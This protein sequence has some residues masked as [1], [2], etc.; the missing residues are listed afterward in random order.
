M[1]KNT[2]SSILF[3]IHCPQNVGYAIE[4][5]IEVFKVTASISGF[6]ES[7]IFFSYTEVI[8]A[9]DPQVIECSFNNPTGFEALQTLMRDKNISH[10]VAFDLNYPEKIIPIIRKNNE[11]KLIAYWGAGISSINSGFKLLLK[12]LEWYFRR[13]KPDRFVFESESMRKTA[14]HGRGIPKRNTSVVNLGT[15]TELFIPSE[16]KNYAY[17]L[18]DI[19]LNRSIVFYSGHMEERKG[20]HIIMQ[21]AITLL[22]MQNFEDVHFVICGNKNGEE[23]VFLKMLEGKKAKQNVTFA[24]YRDDIPQLM[25][26]SSL[27]VIASTGWDSFTMSS[28]EMM[29]SGLPLIVSDL[30]GLSETIE[31]N[32][33]GYLFTPGDSDALAK[34]IRNLIGD[35]K[36]RYKFSVSSRNRAVNLFSE[37]VQAQALSKIIMG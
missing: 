16:N 1:P 13:F 27:G 2:E 14:T 11:L 5:L 10:L 18:F 4:K 32:V 17:D 21:A 9:S 34:Y 28:V 37:E 31:H 24:G 12:R 29:S 25:Q 19:P 6:R 22:D 35:D 3:M 15:N 36:L 7:Q 26:S 33:N 20:V 8:D 23:E 30:E